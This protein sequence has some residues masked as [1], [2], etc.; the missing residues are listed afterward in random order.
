MKTLT[1]KRVLVAA[2]LA[3]VTAVVQAQ[4]PE[5]RAQTHSATMSE[6]TYRIVE[7]AIEDLTRER[8]SEA[9]SRLRTLTDRVR[10]Y[11]RAVVFQTLG[12]VYAQQDKFKPAL[13]AFEEALALE[14]LPQQPQEQ[15][16]YNVGQLYIADGQHDKGIQIVERYLREA[17]TPPPPE[18]HV[19]LAGAY[20][21]RKQWRPALTQ[22]DQAL[23]KAK[24][25]REQWLQLKLAL[26]YELKEYR[27]SAETLVRLIALAPI[28]DDYWKQLSGVLFEIKRDRDSLA[29]LAL[30]ERQG[31]LKTERELR[32]LA[33]VYMLLD[34]PYKAGTLFHQGM[35]RGAVER[36]AENYQFLSDAWI[37][38]REW[39]RAEQALKRAAELSNDGDL[40]KRL[41][42]VYMEKEDYRAAADALDRAVR[43]GVERMGETHYLLGVAAYSMGDQRR[44]ESALRAATRDARTRNQAQQWL[45]HIR[46]EAQHEPL[47]SEGG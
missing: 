18:A 31:F 39:N 34:I 10:G 20:A 46:L 26:H 3:T 35:E 21:E 44:A 47:P 15:L 2:V 4:R 8:H 25:P 14:A 23:E 37:V 38:A 45:E 29:V 9:E 41:G 32:N 42:Q 19:L 40:W 30:A 27:Q 5:C 24:E 1:S 11:E 17:C 33:N 6:G 36:S 28:K 22:V 16:M 12:F 43:A 7:R 13:Q